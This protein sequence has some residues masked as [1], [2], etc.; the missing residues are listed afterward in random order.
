MSFRI[1][2]TFLTSP[3]PICSQVNDIHA[4]VGFGEFRHRPFP[5]S[6]TSFPCNPKQGCLFPNLT[7]I[8]NSFFMCH[9][10]AFLSR[11]LFLS[12][13]FI[14]L[15]FLLKGIFTLSFIVSLDLEGNFDKQYALYSSGRKHVS[16]ITKKKRIETPNM[17]LKPTC[18]VVRPS[19]RA[20]EAPLRRGTFNIW[21]L[22]SGFFV[23]DSV[24]TIDEGFHFVRVLYSE[25][26]AGKMPFL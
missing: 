23:I 5:L 20:Q 15:V 9:E 18:Q 22:R 19:I 2:R 11:C 12:C 25:I 26:E 21:T 17:L 8:P 1:T 7:V 13:F 24:F 3:F 4:G 16:S 6:P 14:T 10:Q